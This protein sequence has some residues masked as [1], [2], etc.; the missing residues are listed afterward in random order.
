M[1]C[2]SFPLLISL[3]WPMSP[4]ENVLLRAHRL[5]AESIEIGQQCAEFYQRQAEA[6]QAQGHT[7]RDAAIL[8]DEEFTPSG[9][10]R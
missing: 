4:E 10:K 9:D 5:L 1:M 6:E 7:T 2:N 8:S 3:G